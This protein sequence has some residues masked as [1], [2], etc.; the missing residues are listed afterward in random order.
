MQG[1]TV[2]HTS[3]F[4]EE[5]LRSCSNTEEH[6]ARHA[7]SLRECAAGLSLR[8][9]SERKPGR[10]AHAHTAPDHPHPRP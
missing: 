9:T 1:T 6:A 10:Q 3:G 4:G 2:P 5:L 7:A 8:A